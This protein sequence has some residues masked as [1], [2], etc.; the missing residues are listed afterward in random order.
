MNTQ[1]S[2]A[3][4][5]YQRGTAHPVLKTKQNKTH[6]YLHVF[7]RQSIIHSIKQE[8]DVKRR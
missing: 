2:E 3:Q 7:P 5:L 1:E 4:E 6:K 8:A